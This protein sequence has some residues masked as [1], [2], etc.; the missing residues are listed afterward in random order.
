M[1]RF[2]GSKVEDAK[3]E[4]VDEV[5]TEG[6]DQVEREGWAPVLRLMEESEV[7]VKPDTIEQRLNPP[8]EHD[9]TERKQGVDGIRRRTFLAS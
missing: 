7:R 5:R 2:E 8:S 1:I 3:G 9:I 4:A 6:F